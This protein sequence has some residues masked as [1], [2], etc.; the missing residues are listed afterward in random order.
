MFTPGFFIFQNDIVSYCSANGKTQLN[1]H[2]SLSIIRLSIM[3]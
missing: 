1:L 3:H 2:N